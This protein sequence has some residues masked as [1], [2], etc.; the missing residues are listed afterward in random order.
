MA[1]PDLRIF[2][3]EQLRDAQLV[4]DV[5][6][7]F[8]SETDPPAAVAAVRESMAAALTPAKLENL[9]AL[10]E[11]W[12]ERRATAAQD[13]DSDFDEL[14]S[15][16]QERDGCCKLCGATQRITIHH[17][18]P[19]LV[20]KRMRNAKKDRINVAAFLVEVCRPCHNELHRLWGHGELAAN[21]QTVEMI[22]AAPEIQGFLTWKRK[23]ERTLE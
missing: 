16:T 23:R 21:Y 6:E 19:K 3:T 15:E 11:E 5:V 18:V 13:S 4:E 17:L 20:L 12:V 8:E 10:L 9:V 22:L 2:L 14:V 1:T 7:L